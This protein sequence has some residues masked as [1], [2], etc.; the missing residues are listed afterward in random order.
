MQVF[1]LTQKYLYNHYDAEDGSCT[2]NMFLVRACLRYQNIRWWWMWHKE[3]G[4]VVSAG[5]AIYNM[6]RVLFSKISV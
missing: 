4:S 6:V 1:A 2:G 5:R 3:Q